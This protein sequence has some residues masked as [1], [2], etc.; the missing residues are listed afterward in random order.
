VLTIF[1]KKDIIQH[2]EVG[3]SELEP[4]NALGCVSNAEGL[5][6]PGKSIQKDGA[7]HAK[8]TNWRMPPGMTSSHP[9]ILACWCARLFRKNSTEW[10]LE[11]M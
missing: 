9:D 10:Q 7:L 8:R 4:K 5:G 2:E 11:G 6:R 1:W 3:G